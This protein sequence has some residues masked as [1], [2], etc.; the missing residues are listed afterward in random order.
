MGKAR[1]SRASTRRVVLFGAALVGIVAVAWWRYVEPVA[2]EGPCV[3]AQ[4]DGNELTTAD[5]ATLRAHA[6][7][8]P[9]EAESAAWA[10]DVALV[11][12]SEGEAS[13]LSPP[14]EALSRYAVWLQRHGSEQDPAARAASLRRARRE[15]LERASLVAGPCAPAGLGPRSVS[16]VPSRAGAEPDPDTDS[17]P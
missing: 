2:V 17:A 10:L 6:L 1:L 12:W 3:V 13:P 15:L 11:G 9:P 16:L 4:W 5:V 14:R 7:P 8:P